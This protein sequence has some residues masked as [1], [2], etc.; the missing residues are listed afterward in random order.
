MNACVLRSYAILSAVAVMSACADPRER[1]AEETMALA[2]AAPLALGPVSETTYTNIVVT[3]S[4]L[5][6]YNRI[7]RYFDPKDSTRAKVYERL[8]SDLLLGVL[9][10]TSH[11]KLRSRTNGDTLIVGFSFERPVRALFS[12]AL[13]EVSAPDSG[14]PSDAV[15]RQFREALTR[16]RREL[17]E[18]D[19]AHF[20]VTPGPRIERIRTA[21]GVRDSIRGEA[22]RG[23]AV[24]HL[25]V[26]ANG[27]RYARIRI[28]DE[29]EY[30]G[31]TVG[32]SIRGLIM[33]IDT[34]W[35]R[36]AEG[37]YV[38][39]RVDCQASS[40]DQTTT[41]DASLSPD[42]VGRQSG[43]F[44]CLWLS[45][46]DWIRIRPNRFRVRFVAIVSGDT[47]AAPWTEVRK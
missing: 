28:R 27:V 23:H 16:V 12:R 29:F 13:S 11:Q 10:N 41:Q 45:P 3:D 8:P 32:G 4:G 40:G 34:T 26:V 15:K 47:I 9:F 25:R 19:T 17:Q 5:A 46:D 38:E 2:S 30:A 21:S 6:D 44:I 36:G 1:A 35:Y 42:L 7:F 31:G 39:Q 43:D 18:T 14:A 24:A 22:V 33:P 20:Y 37:I